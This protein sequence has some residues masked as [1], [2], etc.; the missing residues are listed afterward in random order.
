MRKFFALWLAALA[1]CYSGRAM[2]DPQR[3]L[4]IGDS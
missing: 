1:I 2:A 4:F 3:V